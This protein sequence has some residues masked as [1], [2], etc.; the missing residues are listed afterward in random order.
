MDIEVI[1]LDVYGT[2]LAT[3]DPDNVCRPRNGFYSFVQRMHY[4]GRKLVT[5]SDA[6]VGTQ[7]MDLR[8]TFSH[9]AELTNGKEIITLEDFDAF[10]QLEELPKD[11]RKIVKHYG[12]APK[13]V[14]VIGDNR[15]KDIEGAQRVGCY[16]LL[17]PEYRIKNGYGGFMPQ[18]KFSFDFV[19]FD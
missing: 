3:D 14:L 17:V 11:F 7:R 4:Q 19:E 1:A 12:I 15:F 13:N 9:L 8:A 6:H 10:F 5:A 18:D 2:I 16:S